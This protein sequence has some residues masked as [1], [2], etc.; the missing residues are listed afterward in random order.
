MDFRG[1]PGSLY[2]L[3]CPSGCA[4]AEGNIWGTGIYQTD[5]HICKAAIHSGVL[6]DAGGVF[7]YVIKEGQKSYFATV[8]RDIQSLA[9]ESRWERS[10][11]ISEAT[12]AHLVYAIDFDS[13][14]KVMFMQMNQEVVLNKL[15]STS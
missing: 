13:R 6:Q 12:S 11:V 5:S 4:S 7:L 8:N 2:L 15:A 14:P 1:D 9:Y 10:F 3:K